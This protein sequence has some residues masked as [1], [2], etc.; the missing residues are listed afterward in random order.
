M[1]RE[2]VVVIGAGPGG[3][4]AAI[5][6]ARLGAQVTVIE[7][8][9]IGGACLNH[10][11][12]PTKVLLGSVEALTTTRGAKEFGIKVGGVEPDFSKMMKRKEDII[13]NLRKNA[14]RL[15]Q[16]NKVKFVR[17]SA[18]LINSKKVKIETVGGIKEIEADKII[19]ATGSKP[20]IL[21]LFDYSQPTVLTSKDAL[22]LKEIPESIIIVGAG[23]IGLEFASIF[24][25]L[26]VR[27][28]M[29]ELR[30]WIL[31]AEDKMISQHLQGVLQRGGIKIF[32]GTMCERVI[33]YGADSIVVKLANGPE[34]TAER[35]L[36]SIG[37]QPLSRGFGLKNL[38][39][40][41]DRM[42]TI[43]VN[44]KMET[45]VR[46]IYAVGDVIGGIRLAHVAS[47]EGVVAAENAMGLESVIDYSVVPVC[48]YT[49]PEIASV[50]LTAD[51]AR[52][53][54]E[55]VNV[56]KFSFAVSGR[57]FAIGETAGFVQVVVGEE[58]NKILGT[59]IIGPHATDLIQ[60]AV[61]AIKLGI[62]ARQVGAT[63]HAHPTLSETV[64]EAAKQ[65]AI[66]PRESMVGKIEDLSFRY[67]ELLGF[68]THELMQPLGVLKGY[69]IMMRD[70]LLKIDQQKEAINAMLRNVDML[71]NMNQRYLQFSKIESGELFINK[72]KVK[73][74]QGIICSLIQDES[75]RL[76]LKKMTVKFENEERFKDLEID[77]DPVLLGVV[78]SDL[79]HNALE[80]GI[81]GGRII[82]GFREEENQ[83][84]FNVKNDG[85][86]I[87]KD[88]LDVIFQKFRRLKEGSGKV[89]GTGLGLFNAMEII[90][91][92]EGKIWAESEEGKWANFIFTLPKGP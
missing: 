84:R 20:G 1:I 60:E 22:K 34:V 64:M 69:L 88:K 50:G 45:S 57:A 75:P 15:F 35:L 33:D 39:I 77:V 86:G 9:E 65:I 82:F 41:M 52:A 74:Y 78:Y 31:P 92:H 90:K 8:D 4:M 5:R 71:V 59:Q 10:G 26:G 81:E 6:A 21:P 2:K 76:K 38:G 13:G 43:L 7:K 48:I 36:V 83:Y 79:F 25:P 73:P 62:T 80:Y 49:I 23:V 54:G 55:K 32:T 87:P 85:S 89:R 46:G 91:M 30:D 56:G 53:A 27:V 16:S 29:V 67:M 19:I 58:T 17:G 63:M 61:L 42:G 12:I 14:Y 51:K 68:V 70:G 40:A 3:Q 47:A 37:H 72:A 44:E 18:S 11:C 66:G 24:G 28:I